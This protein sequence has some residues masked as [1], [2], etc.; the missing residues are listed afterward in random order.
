MTISKLHSS[1][2]AA[3]PIHIFLIYVIFYAGHAFYNTY[4]TLFLYGSG[5]T[6]EQ[7]GM[8]SSVFTAILIFI[9]PMWGVIS[10][11]SKNKARIIGV[12]LII[13]A[14]ICLAFYISA[15]ALLAG[16]VRDNVSA[17]FSARLYP[18]GK[19]YA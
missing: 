4:N 13:N 14:L 6:Q 5:L 9:K 15:S 18:S 2:I 3:F 7:I 19:L 8:I 11:R 1:K 10:D 17:L 16:A 12:L